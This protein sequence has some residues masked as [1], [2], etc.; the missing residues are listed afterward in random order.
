M[1]VTRHQHRVYGYAL[2]LLG[3]PDEARDVVQDS[4]LTMWRHRDRVEADGAVSW[5]LRVTHNAAIDRLRRRKVEHRIFEGDADFE[6]LDGG[7]GSPA[8]H[9]ESADMMKHLQAAIDTLKE[10]YRSIVILREIEDYR[11]DEICGA[12]DLPMTTVKVYLH[13]ARKQLRE[14]IQEVLHLEHA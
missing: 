4:M 7:A 1:T 2:R 6:R 5:L 14:T 11:Y 12:L 8:G 9:T 3:D 10:P 13:R